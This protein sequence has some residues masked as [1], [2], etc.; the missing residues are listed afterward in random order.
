VSD[1][2]PNR[3]HDAIRRNIADLTAALHAAGASEGFLTAVAPASTGYDAA[4]EY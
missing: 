3:G 4:N 1:R 2:S